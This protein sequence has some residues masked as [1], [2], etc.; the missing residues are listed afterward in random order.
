MKIMK[1]PKKTRKLFNFSE[2]EYHC[3]MLERLVKYSH[4][5]GGANLAFSVKVSDEKSLEN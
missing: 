1:Y 2:P 4:I 3:I 5:N